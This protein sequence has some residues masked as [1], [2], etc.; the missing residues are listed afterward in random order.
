LRHFPE[1]ASQTFKKGDPL[2]FGNTAGNENR[3]KI[4]GADPAG[5]IG[6]AAQDASGTT[7]TSIPVWVAIEGCEFLV[8]YADTQA[9]DQTDLGDAGFGIVADGTNLIWRLDNTE[10]TAKVFKVTEL[11]DADADVNGRAA[12]IVVAAARLL[13]LA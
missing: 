11:I 9:I 3:V 13:H 1:D 5:I 4:A 7:G 2:I 10:T 6:F 12:A 8:R